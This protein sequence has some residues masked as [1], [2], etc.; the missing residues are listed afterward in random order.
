MCQF[1]FLNREDLGNVKKVGSQTGL[2]LIGH[3]CHRI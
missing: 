3:T 1:T 2:F